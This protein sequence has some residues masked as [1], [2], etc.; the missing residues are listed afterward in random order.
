MI[1]NKEIQGKD[2]EQKPEERIKKGNF[3]TQ[4]EAKKR[5]GI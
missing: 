5:L 2:I 1:S 4:A 3:L